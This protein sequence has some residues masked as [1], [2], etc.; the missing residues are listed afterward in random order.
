MGNGRKKGGSFAGE[1]HNMGIR[2][3][4]GTRERIEINSSNMRTTE[5]VAPDVRRSLL[6][7]FDRRYGY[8]LPLEY[9]PSDSLL[10][11]VLGHHKRRCA[12]FVE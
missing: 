5:E 6:E 3:D 1:G 12:E 11:L 7:A 8:R 4:G 2:P 10:A 9:Q